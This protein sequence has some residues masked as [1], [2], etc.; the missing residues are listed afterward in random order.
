MELLTERH[1]DEIAGVLS[2][3]DR[4]LIQGTLPGLCYAEGMTAYLKARQIRI[5]D[6]AHFAQPLRD[7]LRDPDGRVRA[8]A[9]L[10]CWNLG[11]PDNRVV[12]V[13][14]ELLW[15]GNGEAR[16]EAAR[17]LW[18]IARTQESARVLIA[19]LRDGDAEVRA[20]ASEALRSLGPE[21]KRFVPLL[22]L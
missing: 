15:S 16:V 3:Y 12:A 4:I 18:C 19:L 5:F 21:A 22:R 1:A 9:A 2:C 11:G 13:L 8:R 7:A 14:A 20:K 6:Y 10:A 17:T